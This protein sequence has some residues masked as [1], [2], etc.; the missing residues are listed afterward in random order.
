VLVVSGVTFV[1]VTGPLRTD[2]TP[3]AALA[4]PH[5]V[6]VARAAGITHRYDGDFVHFTGGGVAALD[7]DD[8]GLQDLYFAGGSEPAALY[9]NTSVVGGAL[10]FERVEDEATGLVDAVGA[11]PLD[12][13]GDGLADL[14]VLRA[15]ENVLLRGLGA[16]HF[17]RANE[18]LDFDGGDVW[19]ASFSATWEAGSPL[20]TLA[21][22]NYLDRHAYADGRYVCEDNELHRPRA[23]G[24]GYQSPVSLS[25]GYCALSMLFSD[26]DRSGRRDLRVSND[27]QYYRD[28]EEQLWRVEAGASPR[29]YTAA[30]GWQTLR[31]W[32]MGIASHDVT[33]DGRPDYFLTSQADNKLQALADGAD[34]PRYEDVALR[35]GATAH[36]PHQ[37]DTTMPSTA[38][39]AEFGDV[40]NDGFMDL[41]VTKGNVEA[42][43]EYAARDPNNL[44]LGQ[45]DGTFVEAAPE[46]GIVT[47]E[48][49]RGAALVDLNLDGLLDI[50]VVNRRVNVAVWRNLGA[51]ATEAAVSRPMGGWI[52]LRLDQDGPNRDAVG[53]WLTARAGDRVTRIELTVGGGHASG[54]SGWIHVGIGAAESAEVEVQWPDGQTEAF[55]PVESGTF[56][57]LARGTGQAR[58]WSPPGG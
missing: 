8:D 46:A 43:T 40:N 4:A 22:G 41:F 51:A 12:V 26:W 6:E 18:A 20:P 37:G 45:P 53:A 36:R 7:C 23:D 25:P 50:V 56:A 5:F 19:S 54:E 15:G 44:L 30:E 33:G 9:R 58:A 47:F 14:A 57:L 52:A 24:T 27:R 11:Y 35:L 39:H 1:A 49:G 42:Q 31:I 13:D 16:C 38:W 10:R 32:G 28:G 17:E 3:A 29:L 55:G 48:R 21:V 34:A 2:A